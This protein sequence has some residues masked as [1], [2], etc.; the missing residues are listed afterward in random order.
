MASATVRIE[1]ISPM[2]VVEVEVRRA[3]WYVLLFAPI[4]HSESPVIGGGTCLP[5]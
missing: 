1:D 2:N 5:Y 3:L 4:L